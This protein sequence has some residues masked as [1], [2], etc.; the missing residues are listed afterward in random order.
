M[1]DRS[2]RKRDQRVNPGPFRTD[3]HYRQQ[4]VPEG[5]EACMAFVL[6]E[7]VIEAPGELVLGDRRLPIACTITVEWLRGIQEP[8]W[9]GYFTPHYDLRMLPGPYRIVIGG[10]EYRILLRRLTSAIPSSIPFWGLG[11][12][13]P[14]ERTS[15]PAPPGTMNDER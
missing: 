11:D 9:Y 10:A 13:P 15:P 5:D 1:S 7:G 6:D 4:S 2:P 8:T 14:V 3:S 12:P